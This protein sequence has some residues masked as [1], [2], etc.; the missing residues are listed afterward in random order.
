VPSK[1]SWIR[2]APLLGHIC[3]F[4]FLHFFSLRSA[5]SEEALS[6]F[7]RAAEY[8]LTPR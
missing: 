8:Q 2:F 5:G 1:N 3:I 4:H 6:T 7:K